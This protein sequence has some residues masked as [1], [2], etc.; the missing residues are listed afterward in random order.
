MT[1]RSSDA[2]HS[3]LLPVQLLFLFTLATVASAQSSSTGPAGPFVAPATLTVGFVGSLTLP[4]TNAISSGQPSLLS[5]KLALDRINADPNLLPNTTLVGAIC[6]SKS[7]ASEVIAG[8]FRLINDAGVVGI[9]GEAQSS[10][11][12]YVA[13]VSKPYKMTQVSFGSSSTDFT[14]GHLKTYPYFARPLPHVRY[15]ATALTAFV[16]SQGWNRFAIVSTTDSYGS[17]GQAAMVSM[18]STLGL[19]VLATVAF[20]QGAS[21]TA[22]QFQVQ[23]IIDSGARIIA[24]W[25][26]IGDLLLLW[27]VAATMSPNVCGE[28]YQW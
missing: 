19:T 6:D 22:L 13:Y 15:E 14:E 18:A 17:A 10:M 24:F 5:F 2:R 12:Q 26:V 4:N 25:G 23:Q 28:G 16:Q 11:S 27:N 3:L 21:V 7:D 8:T 20:D 1:P 9:I